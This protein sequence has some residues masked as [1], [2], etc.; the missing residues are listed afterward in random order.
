MKIRKNIET[1]HDSYFKSFQ[2]IYKKVCDPNSRT[3]L[4]ES[5]TLSAHEYQKKSNLKFEWMIYKVT[6]RENI[7]NNKKNTKNNSSGN[8]KMSHLE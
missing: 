4:K 5:H 6:E 1:K 3:K 2:N 7:L 8:V